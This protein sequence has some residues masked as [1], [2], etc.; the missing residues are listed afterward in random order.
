MT[1][2]NGTDAGP[3]QARLG[4]PVPCARIQHQWCVDVVNYTA[5]VVQHT[6]KYDGLLPQARGGRFSNNGVTHWSDGEVV[7]E[8]VDKQ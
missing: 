4:T 8:R 5:D 3:E 1:L 7:D 6:C 2:T